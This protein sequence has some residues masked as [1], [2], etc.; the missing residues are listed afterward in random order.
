MPAGSSTPKP[1]LTTQLLARAH[2]P[3][4]AKR[5]FAEK[6]QHKPLLLR[7]TTLAESIV[8]ART[9][10]RNKRRAQEAQRKKKPRPLTAAEKRKSCVYDIPKEEK[11]YELYAGLN[12]MWRGYMREILGV[13]QQNDDEGEPARQVYLTPAGA[14]PKIASADFHGA[15]VEVVRSRCVSR[16]GVLG[17]VVRDTKFTFVVITKKNE[18]KCWLRLLTKNRTRALTISH[19]A[20]PK[21]HTIFKIE[22]PISDADDEHETEESKQRPFLTFELHGEHFQNRAPERANKKF[23][24]RI[25][26]DL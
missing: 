3:T 7:P 24:L 12:K 16:V 4:S 10:R 15:D 2:S 5:I 19:T 6:I 17:I 9:T 1:S 25:P 23:K 21:E 26:H 13:G 22:V 18:I 8:D 20:I 11:R 14:G